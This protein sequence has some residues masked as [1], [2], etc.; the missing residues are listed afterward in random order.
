MARFQLRGTKATGGA[1]SPD[2]FTFAYE[3][4]SVGSGDIVISF[5]GSKLT[6]MDHVRACLVAALR[7]M[8]SYTGTPS[9]PTKAR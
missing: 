6:S 5:D 1:L 4:E 8:D 9:H 3:T 7:A 2:Q